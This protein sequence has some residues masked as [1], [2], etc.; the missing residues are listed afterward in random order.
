MGIM[1]MPRIPIS[2]EYITYKDTDYLIEKVKWDI[3]N[4]HVIL[5][6]K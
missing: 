2:G 6:A 4:G 1:E 3:T 5:V